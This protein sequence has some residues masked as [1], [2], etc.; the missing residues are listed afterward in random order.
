MDVIA[1]T[2]I[3]YYIGRG[4]INP[5]L[6]NPLHKL[7][8]NYNNIDELCSTRNLIDHPEITRRAIQALFEHSRDHAIF[9]SP[10][11]YIKKL[12]E[13]K[14]TIDQPG[15]IDMLQFFE[16][17]AQGE[18]IDLSDESAFLQMGQERLD[19][20][21]AAADVMNREAN[22]IRL[23]TKNKKQKKRSDRMPQVR[24]L[25]RSLVAIQSGDYGLPNEYDWSAIELF[26]NVLLE[27]YISLEKGARV[28]KPNDWYDL[29]ILAY[30]RPGQKIWTQ[31]KKWI[32]IIKDSGMKKYL[33]DDTYLIQK[34]LETE[35]LPW[36]LWL[37]YVVYV[38]FKRIKK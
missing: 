6:L 22:I 36:Y 14:F 16:R 28:F 34:K 27:F 17:I 1:D 23:A 19:R 4:D 3:W 9:D 12:H 29:F 25:I 30:V 38:F 5:R 21:Q 26:E 33:Y 8:G 24:E 37:W 18:S 15:T 13:P 32:S 7:I 31:E 20:L 35:S 11:I 2:H 10:L